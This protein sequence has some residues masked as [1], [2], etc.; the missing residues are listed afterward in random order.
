M[1]TPRRT[2]SAWLALIALSAPLAWTF[3]DVLQPALRIG[4]LDPD[5]DAD[6][7]PTPGMYNNWPSRQNDN[8]STIDD[9]WHAA[10]NTHGELVNARTPADIL[11]AMRDSETAAQSVGIPA[12]SPATISITS[13][14]N[15]E[16]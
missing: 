10:T 11:A 2:P 9:I 5:V 1:Q 16:G 14:E 4:Y 7:Y 13:R 15:W 3:A 8:R 6:P 12:P